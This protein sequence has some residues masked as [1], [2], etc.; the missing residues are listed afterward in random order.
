MTI[1][2]TQKVA[3]IPRAALARRGG[4]DGVF[5]LD[6]DVARFRWLRTGRELG[7]TIEVVSGL[8]GGEKIIA[9]VSDAV[10]DGLAVGSTENGR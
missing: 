8:S 10:R 7:D 4:L 2:G 3:V 5:I 9:T 1:L 6:G